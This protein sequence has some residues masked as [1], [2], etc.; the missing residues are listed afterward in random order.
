MG[1]TYSPRDM[2]AR[3]ISFDTVSAHSNKPMID[4]M[5]D[6]L[7]GHGIA[8][9]I[10]AN[11]EGTKADI[12]A[13]IGP[14]EAGGI[15]FSG[16]TDVVPVEGQ[17]WTHDPFEMVEQDG[18]LFGRG[19][20]DM[21]G[22]LGVCLALVP[23]MQA[24]DLKRPLHLVFSYD[25]EVGCL[26]APA[27]IARMVRDIPMP[28]A[29]IIGEPTGMKLVNANKGVAIFR[30]TVTGKPAHSSQTH[31]GVNAIQVAARCITFLEC[32][33]ARFAEDGHTDDRFMPPHA[34]ICVGTI[35]GGTALNIIAGECSFVWDCR[36]LLTGDAETA[37]SA[38]VRYCE[39]DLIPA[40]QDI[41]P[42]ADIVT[43]KQISAPPLMASDDNP[44]EALVRQLTGQNDAGVV[45]FATE[46]GLF[47][48]SGVPSVIC[49][50]GSIDQAHQPD[51]F[52]A[53]SQLDECTDFVRKIAY[54]AAG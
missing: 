47:Q 46:A 19:T 14:M 49:G 1:E 7:A 41:A 34:T 8:T 11:E 6:Y 38:L 25:E 51:E 18:K 27:L 21:K 10:A 12:I 35:E 16:H 4:F 50:P 44:A 42:E 26:G 30:T 36:S 29:A 31:A 17:A 23:E 20:C 43:E 53:V 3:L 28:Q 13:T 24:L 37:M 15:V 48:D 2:L 22:F 9:N 40:M 39:E 5:A 45:A 33:A 52:L 54:W 32:Q